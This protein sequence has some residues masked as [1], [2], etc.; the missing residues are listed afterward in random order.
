[1]PE[2]AFPFFFRNDGAGAADA[3]ADAPHTFKE[4]TVAVTRKNI[5]N[6]FFTAGNPVSTPCCQFDLPVWI[7]L[8]K[9]SFNGSGNPAG[10][11]IA[12]TRRRSMR[13]RVLRHF[14]RVQIRH[15]QK[16]TQFLISQDI[17]NSTFYI[18]FVFSAF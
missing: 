14:R 15:G 12:D 17:I 10:I 9:S 5:V 6:H 16:I 2:P 3:A 8:F 18:R 7:Q 13:L 1:M 4:V 11:G